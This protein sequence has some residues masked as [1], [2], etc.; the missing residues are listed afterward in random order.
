MLAN[1]RPLLS[2]PSFNGV[3]DE[4]I[5]GAGYLAAALLALAAII[6]ALSTVIPA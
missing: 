3:Q 2:A 6:P 1:R 4:R 5:G